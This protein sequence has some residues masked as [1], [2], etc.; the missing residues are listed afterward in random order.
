VATRILRHAFDRF[1][2]EIHQHQC[3]GCIRIDS[4]DTVCR[5]RRHCFCRRKLLEGKATV[6]A[7]VTFAHAKIDFVS[8]CYAISYGL[9]DRVQRSI[10]RRR[11]R[12]A[13][14]IKGTCR[15]V[16]YCVLCVRSLSNIALIM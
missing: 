11:G 5:A 2:R 4:G 10:H 7:L 8:Q 14:E 9:L 6:Q 3:A 1:A 12:G 13:H 16:T 15:S